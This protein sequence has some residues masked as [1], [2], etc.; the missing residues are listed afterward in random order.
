MELTV[1]MLRNDEEPPKSCELGVSIS[2]RGGNRLPGLP[3]ELGVSMPRCD[4]SRPSAGK[5]G[6]PRPAVTTAAQVRTKSRVSMSHRAG[7]LCHVRG[8]VSG[9]RVGSARES[10]ETEPVVRALEFGLYATRASVRLYAKSCHGVRLCATVMG[11]LIA[12]APCWAW[13]TPLDT[14]T[15]G[16]SPT[17][18]AWATLVGCPDERGDHVRT[19]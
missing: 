12:G 19:S 14:C 9:I 16:E 6:F 2:R 8:G 4:G 7:N 5:A 17:E 3:L 13:R 18:G 1:S 11:A 10:R 15:M